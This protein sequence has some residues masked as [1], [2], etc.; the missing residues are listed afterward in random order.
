MYINNQQNKTKINRCVELDESSGQ[1]I[2][3]A[4]IKKYEKHLKIV[5]PLSELY[6]R[7]A[8][9]MYAAT[10]GTGSALATYRV[11]KIQK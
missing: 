10:L 3:Q 5:H 6:L 4:S 2:A 11:K 9:E 7:I 1:K 8:I